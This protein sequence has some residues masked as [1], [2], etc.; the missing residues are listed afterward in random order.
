MLFS[1]KAMFEHRRVL[2]VFLGQVI[3]PHH[4]FE[5]DCLQPSCF[6]NA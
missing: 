2:T 1:L 4:S 6:S 3:A 5:M